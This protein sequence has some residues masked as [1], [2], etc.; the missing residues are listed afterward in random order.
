MPYQL[1]RYNGQVLVTVDDGV[2]DKSATSLELVGKNFAGYGRIQNESFVYLLENFANSNPPT[3]PING[4]IWYDSGEKRLK[5]FDSTI[6]TTEPLKKWRTSA[7]TY[8]G[9][10]TPGTGLNPLNLVI[11]DLFFNTSTKQ[12]YTYNGTDHVLI[13]PQAVANAGVT[14]LESIS[15]TDTVPANHP[16][17]KAT[18]DAKVVF[19]VSKDTFTLASP[20]IPGFT[21]INQGVTL[22]DSTTGITTSD[23]RFWGTATDSD[24]LGG[25]DSD[26]YIQKTGAIFTALT[27]FPNAG[28]TIGSSNNIKIYI[29]TTGGGVLGTIINQVSKTLSF[30]VTE[31]TVVKEPFR[32]SGD[33]VIP[34]DTDTYNLGISSY[35]WNTVYVKNL[36]ADTIT[37]GVTGIASKSDSLKYAR[38]SLTDK[39]STATDESVA[40]TI[41][42]RDSS[43]N[44][45]ANIITGTA[46]QARY[47]DLAEKYDADAVYEPGT[48]VVFGGDKE[49]TITDIEEDTRVAGVIS[50]NP[51]YL[52]NVDSEGL[53]VALRGKVPC[54]VI[55]PVSKGDVLVSSNIPGYARRGNV[56]S[57]AAS[58]VGKSLEDKFDRDLGTIMVVVS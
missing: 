18:V 31:D 53:A 37:G 56:L 17:V 39:Y 49:I 43:A 21:H 26:Q 9:I 11:G 4:Q 24:R 47:A 35:R 42:A 7:G 54:K 6:I 58:I 2:T 48:V 12:L 1:N 30:K 32:I 41:V 50:T 33:N 8:T 25:I 34:G 19:I 51:A 44:F 55:G 28:I 10:S 40:N 3:N 22:V 29:D 20:A 45:A 46:T 5:F 15:V 27:A 14:N 36:Y 16:I 57:P 38:S 13:G 23:Y 52:M